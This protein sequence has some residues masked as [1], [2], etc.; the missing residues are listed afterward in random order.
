MG[1][2]D[3]IFGRKE[4][5]FDNLREADKCL[6]DFLHMKIEQGAN[7]NVRS[8]SGWTPLMWQADNLRSG[9]VRKLIASGADVNAKNDRGWTAL[10]YAIDGSW[11]DSR[12][13]E[14]RLA[15][16]RILV[17]AGADLNMTF[18]QWFH[19]KNVQG[20]LETL[21][22][23]EFAVRKHKN[24]VAEWLRQKMDEFRNLF[25]NGSKEEIKAAI[26]EGQN[27]NAWD[28]KR[29][30]PLMLA[31]Q[32]PNM[33]EEMLKM[34]LDAGANVNAQN[35]EGRTP[36]MFLVSNP[37]M[38]VRV[39]KMLLKAGVDVHACFYEDDRFGAKK[40]VDALDVAKRANN[41]EAVSILQLLS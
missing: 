23:Y 16:V 2:F 21:T 29:N 7:V 30:T 26:D 37:D 19:D 17:E 20:E 4:G 31:S 39:L 9:H 36:L 41:F 38:D 40:G 14:L 25:L 1:F 28:S 22:P 27:V 8:S 12:E 3:G 5:P 32:N 11:A 15:C 13:E 34:L 10:I 24:A 33:D 18:E 6:F 35:I